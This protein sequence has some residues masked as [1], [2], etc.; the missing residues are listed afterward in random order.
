MQ[1]N[2]ANKKSP[3]K[4]AIANGFVNGS[5]P[6]EVRWITSNSDTKKRIIKN[7]EVT[8]ILNAMMAPVRPYGS[9]FAHTGGAQKFIRGNYQ[10]FEMDKNRIGGVILQLNKL[11]FGE[12]IYCVLCGRMTANQRRIVRERSKVVTQLLLIL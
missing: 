3:P 5:F 1:P 8:D 11:G 7:H 2:M 10:F 4:F 6:Q 12:H 9:I